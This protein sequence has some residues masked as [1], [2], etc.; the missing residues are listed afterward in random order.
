MHALM[1]IFHGAGD[2]DDRGEIHHYSSAAENLSSGRKNCDT[3]VTVHT[4]CGSGGVSK[5]SAAAAHTPTLDI[6][7]CHRPRSLQCIM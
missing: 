6:F 3:G 1:R 2:F 7:N 5:T 4:V